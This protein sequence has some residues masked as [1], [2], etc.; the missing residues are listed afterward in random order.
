MTLNMHGIGIATGCVENIVR[1]TFK[2]W[3]VVQ[4]IH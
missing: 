3:P 4:G 1:K 2:L